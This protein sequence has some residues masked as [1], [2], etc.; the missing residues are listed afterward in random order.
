MVG[1]GEGE[2]ALGLVKGLVEGFAHGEGNHLVAIAVEDQGGDI[3]SGCFFV[4]WKAVGEE[5]SR[6][7]GNKRGGQIHEVGEGS[8]QD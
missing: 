2:K 1:A 4:V 8:F 7:N 6:E 5:E 3:D